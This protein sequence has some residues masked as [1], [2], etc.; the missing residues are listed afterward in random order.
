MNDVLT[1]KT[2]AK[3]KSAQQGGWRLNI[4]DRDNNLNVGN[5]GVTCQST[6]PKFWSG[7]RTTM[8]VAGK[9]KYYYE[10]YIASDGLCRVGWS[11]PEAALNLGTDDQGFGFGGTGKKSH[12]GQFDDYGES[13]TLE[14][15]IGCYLDLDE[16][17]IHFSKN[18]KEFPPAFKIKQRLVNSHFFPSVVIKNACLK[19]NYGDQPFRFPPAN[20]F[21]G[22]AKAPASL[23][24]ESPNNAFGGV[25]VNEKRPPNA[26]MCVILEP[27]KELAQQT[28]AQIERFKKNVLVVG[29][30]SISEQ[31]D[32]IEVG[33]DIITCT[34]GRVRDLVHQHKILLNHVRFF[35][36][37]EADSLVSGQ[38]DAWKTIQELHSKMPKYSPTGERLQMIVCSATL[39]NF[40]VKKLADQF[41]HF[42]QW[43]DLK[44]QDVVPDTVHQVVCIVDP[45]TDKS[46][47]RLRAKPG[48][49]IKTDGIHVRDDIRP[50]SDTPETL[51]EGAKVL[52][53][54]YVTKAI[55][56]HK[57]DKCI[58][59]CRTKLDCDNMEEFLSSKGKPH[60][61]Y[62]YSGRSEVERLDNLQK[63]KDNKARF[64]ICTD[65]A[66]RGIDIHGV[67]Y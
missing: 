34:P 46:W 65:V 47:I 31:M 64:L 26:P 53:G 52:K 60:S 28:Y 6:H 25:K 18:G 40:D 59:F 63:F 42:P 10:A 51:S 56:E 35:V 43:V 11:T 16:H 48:L 58:I 3:T 21:V 15:T 29:G 38:S 22:V 20:G 66:A 24:I 1:G 61:Q 55:E 14:D 23:T 9:G 41:M 13:F 19:L 27:T 36:L 30:I 49:S 32:M 5:D 39:H 44:G 45:K 7:C 37:D 50:G 17:T 67:P 4:F 54:E 8:G 2:A 57:M 62:E 12:D 33:V